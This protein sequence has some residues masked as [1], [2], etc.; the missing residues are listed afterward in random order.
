M[1]V[2]TAMKH[3]VLV[4]AGRA[5]V[6]LRPG[7]G[8]RVVL[9]HDGQADV[10]LDLLL[11]RLVTPGQVGREQDRGTGR[12]DEPGGADAD[13][14][15]L[16]P[17]EQL[18]D[19][20]PDDPRR[21]FRAG[22][23]GGPLQLLDDAPAGVDDSRGDLG[24][25]DI[26]PDRQAHDLALREGAPAPRRRRLRPVIGGRP[27]RGGPACSVPF[28]GARTGPSRTPTG[29]PGRPRRRRR[30]RPASCPPRPGP[31]SLIR[32]AAR[33]TGHQAHS[34]ASDDSGGGSVV[35]VSQT[36]PVRGLGPP[37]GRPCGTARPAPGACCG[38]PTG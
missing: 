21:L 11:Q 36:R 22:R 8:V 3:D 27:R 26:N 16:V 2:P 14:V 35:A 34:G 19:G 31:D 24:A 10:L 12:V 9:H 32:R 30:R 4:P 37:A 28:A 25:P 13:G 15:D 29:L 18:G 6:G 7:G 33:H 38:H 20:I 17:A 1:P 23:G 5:Q